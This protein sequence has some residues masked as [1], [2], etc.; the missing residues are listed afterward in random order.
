MEW[1]EKSSIKSIRYPPKLV[2]FTIGKNLSF[3]P[4]ML[5]N[6]SF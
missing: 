1:A 3:N 5:I 2:I 4:L 6:I